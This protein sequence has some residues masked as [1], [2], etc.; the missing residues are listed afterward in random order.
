[1]RINCVIA[2]GLV[3]V[4]CN[5]EP[6]D[7]NIRVESPNIGTQQV[8]AVYTTEDGNRRSISV[9]AVD[10]AFEF[11]GSSSTPSVVEIFTSNKQLYAAVIAQNGES[12]TLRGTDNGFEVEGSE[13]AHLFANYKPGNDTIGLPADVRNAIDIVYTEHSRDNRPVFEA[14]ELIIGR[15]SV[16]TLPAEGVWVFTSSMNER[17]ESLLDTLRARAKMEPPLRDVFISTDTISW[18]IYTRRDSATWTQAMLPDGPLALRGILTSTPLLV[19]VDSLG[20]VTRV[21]S[22]E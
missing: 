4:A 9:A 3:L 8:T 18:R 14:P 13:R 2:I 19:E 7:F 10:G 5:K 1:M 22:L 17:T 11:V 20:V 15:D 21:Q 16:T 6:K 12:I